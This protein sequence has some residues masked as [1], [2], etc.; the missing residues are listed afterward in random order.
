MRNEIIFDKHG[1]PDIVVTYTAAELEE[2]LGKNHP[3]LTV[4]GRRISELCVGKYPA[5]MIEGLPYSLPFQKPAGRL[6]FD[7]ARRFCEAKGEGWH[8][9][10]AAEWAALALISLKNGTQPHGNTN[11]GKYHADQ[12]EEGIKIDGSGMTL[13]GSGPVTW[14]HTHTAEG[15]HDLTGNQF[16]WIGGLRYMDGA[17][18]IIP[19]NDAAGGADQ[20]PQSSAWA[21]VLSEGKPVKFKICDDHIALTTEDEIEKDWDGC[22]FKDLIAEC[23]VPEILKQLAIFP[24]DVSQIGDDFFWVDTDGARLVYRGGNWN[25]GG[26]AGVFYASGNDPRSYYYTNLGFRPA[27]VRFSEIC[28]SDT[29]EEGAEA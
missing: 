27:F 26:N 12:N 25:L 16:E 20:S 24:D 5:T 3:V 10:T 1:R 13:T 14:T 11:A 15:V 4:K 22:S 17:I 9:L 21:S 6:N 28:D 19:D 8:L 2:L 23:D 18:Q 7:E 29:L